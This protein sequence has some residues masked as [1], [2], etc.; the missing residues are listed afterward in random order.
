MAKTVALIG[1]FDTKGEEFTF[2]RERIESAGLRTLMINVGVLGSATFEADISPIEVAAA[3][4]QNLA[5]LRAERDRGRS[6]TAMA[7]G[8]KAILQRLFE[9]GAIHGVVSLGGSA[10]TAIACAAMR[11]LPFSFPKLM[12]STL[13]SG[14]IRPYV[15]T[16]DI[17]MMPSVLDIAGLNHVSRRIIGNAAAAICGMV[18]SEPAIALNQKPAIAATMFGVT[19]PCVTAARQALEERGFE[20]LVFHATGTGGQA[21]EQLIEDGAFRAVLDMTTTELADELVGGVMSAGPH[22]L[23]A[24]GRKGIPQVVC[25]GAIDMVNFGPVETVPPQFCSRNLYIHN[26]SV[27]LMRTTPEECAEIGRITATRLNRASGPVT[28]LIPLL[29]VSAIDKLGGPF[30]SP[31]ALDAYRH[32]LRVSLSSSIRIVE[33]D[34]HINDEGFASV[35]VDLMIELLVASI[36]T[37]THSAK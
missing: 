31:E 2:L 26:P 3:A 18:A 37:E 15:G 16:S 12:V 17:C 14:D 1:T 7:T 20:V 32:A 10:G 11:A 35:A 30:Y 25:P 4:N 28:V 33:L 21:M 36:R 19:T 24:A 8:A 6:V 27:T 9:Q 13:A 5:A 29:G 23:E 34:A 22:R